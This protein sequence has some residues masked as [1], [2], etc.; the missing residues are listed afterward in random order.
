[1]LQGEHADEKSSNEKHRGVSCADRLQGGLNKQA[2]QGVNHQ[3]RQVGGVQ[4]EAHLKKGNMETA[5]QQERGSSELRCCVQFVIS[6]HYIV[7]SA[8][9]SRNKD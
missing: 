1:M 7:I 9:K 5:D 3:Y 6:Q 2:V 8:G 4:T